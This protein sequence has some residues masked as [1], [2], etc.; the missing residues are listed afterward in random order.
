[1]DS[2]ARITLTLRDGTSISLRAREIRTIKTITGGSEV[3]LEIGVKYQVQQSVA[4]IA[5][6]IDTLW[7]EYTAALGDPA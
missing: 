6:S 4:T 1:M 3:E 5:S 7:D 2:L